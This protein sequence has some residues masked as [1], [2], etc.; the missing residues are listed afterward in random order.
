MAHNRQPTFWR[1]LLY[2]FKL[3]SN[4]EN[5]YNG[6]L[7]CAQAHQWR[8]KFW[9]E[10]S[11]TNVIGR[12]HRQAGL[13]SSFLWVIYYMAKSP[14]LTYIVIQLTHTLLRSQIMLFLCNWGFEPR[15]RIYIWPKT[16]AF[17]VSDYFQDVTISLFLQYNYLRNNQK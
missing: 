12:A 2:F 1:L 8:P 5:I 14:L 9:I 3:S 4:Q 17:V 6:Y 7:L 11:S 13:Y 16:Q 15:C 10:P